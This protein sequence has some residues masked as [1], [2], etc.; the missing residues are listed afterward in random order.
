MEEANNN[1]APQDTASA[2]DAGGS[3][4]AEV[5][6]SAEDREMQEEMAQWKQ[7]LTTLRDKENFEDKVGYKQCR[8][9][10]NYPRRY[11]NS[12]A[13]WDHTLIIGDISAFIPAKAGTRFSDP[14]PML[15]EN[16]PTNRKS[17][18]CRHTTT[19]HN[20]LHHATLINTQRGSRC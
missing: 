18:P 2:A 13:L 7:R 5:I 12:R 20:K 3:E 6:E 4:S 9:V 14:R 19:S 17:V 15:R 10:C 1:T 8:A 11:G 16:G